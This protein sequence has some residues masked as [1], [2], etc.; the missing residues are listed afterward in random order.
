MTE[1]S[2]AQLQA[3]LIRAQRIGAI[4]PGSI[5]DQVSHSRA[6]AALLSEYVA[7]NARVVDLGSGGGL[8]GLVLADLLPQLVLCFLDGRT[9]RANALTESLAALGRP[10]LEVRGVRAELAGRDPALRKAFQ[11]VVARAFGPPATTAECAAP[12][13]KVG[14]VLIVSEPPGV[15]A[16]SRWPADCERLGLELERTVVEPFAFA[17][18]RQVAPCPERYPRRVGVPRKRPLF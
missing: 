10:D 12:F 9:E 8:P 5:D 3:V 2:Q 16:Q 4:G 13:L 14:G 17:V 11:A 18:L 7:P 6:F 1:P 15:S